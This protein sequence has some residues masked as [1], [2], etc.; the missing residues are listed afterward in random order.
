MAIVRDFNGKRPRVGEG[1]FLAENAVLVGD[2][3]VGERAS[4]WY[5]AVLRGDVFHIRVGDETSI[6]DN[7][8]IHVT[9]GRNAT[10]IGRRVTI[11]HAVTLHGCAIGDRC[12]IGMG[13]TILDHAEIGERCIIGAGALVTPGTKIPAGTLAVGSPARPK[14]DLTPDEEKW[15]DASADH[16]IDLARAYLNPNP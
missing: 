11:G 9:H 2:V 3:V 13:S 1:T 16:Y 14:R 8:V 7:S 6:Q 10:V 15:I 5:G 4:I 12:I